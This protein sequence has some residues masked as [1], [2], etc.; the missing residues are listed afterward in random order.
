VWCGASIVPAMPMVEEI[1]K[2]L[3]AEPFVPFSITTD[4]GTVRPV[5]S[6]DHALIGRTHLVLLD[7]LR[8]IELINR[9]KITSVS[10]KEEGCQP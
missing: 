8:N 4:D 2:L 5:Q 3:Q 1:Q 9:R 7:T 10:I 6:R